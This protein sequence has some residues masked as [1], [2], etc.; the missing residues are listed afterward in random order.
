MATSE[1]LGARIA[2]MEN[3]M[4]MQS[5]ALS[6]SRAQ[7]EAHRSELT[8]MMQDLHDTVVQTAA[9]Q[10]TLQNA[11]Q[12]TIAEPAEEVPLLSPPGIAGDPLGEQD[13]RVFWKGKGGGKGTV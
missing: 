12:E 13:P 5:G 6:D 9:L 10:Q 8:K 2:A 11:A 7:A 3:T 1:E 4:L